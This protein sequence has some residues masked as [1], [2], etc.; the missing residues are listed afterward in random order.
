MCYSLIMETKQR[1]SNTSRKVRQLDWI[2]A[3][4]VRTHNCCFCNKPLVEGYNPREPGKCVTLHHSAGSRE[5]DRWDDLEYVSGMLPAHS[6][7]H[8]AFHLRDRLMA[9]GKKVDSD[10]M[11]TE[12]A[13]LE[14]A[15]RS[16]QNK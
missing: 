5:E 8:R 16:A 6:S 13:N 2:F 15:V 14:Q 12:R 1:H 11:V 4:L 10:R 9:S 7:C 3:W